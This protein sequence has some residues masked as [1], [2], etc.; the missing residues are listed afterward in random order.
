ML[1]HYGNYMKLRVQRK[2]FTIGEVFGFVEQLKIM[3]DVVSYSIQQTT[4]EQIF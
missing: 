2:E 3:H 4:L 1:E